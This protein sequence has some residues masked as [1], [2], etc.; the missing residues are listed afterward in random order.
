MTTL[1]PD[2][3]RDFATAAYARVGMPP[4]DARL[5][6]DTLED[7]IKLAGELGIGDQWQARLTHTTPRPVPDGS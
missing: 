7:V 6:A 3:L 2:Q 4:D 5:A 1:S